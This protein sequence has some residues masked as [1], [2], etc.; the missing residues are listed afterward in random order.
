MDAADTSLSLLKLDLAIQ[1][2]DA[3]EELARAVPVKDFF[4]LVGDT[5]A[6]IRV[7]LLLVIPS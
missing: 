6:M 5:I 2:L 3:A 1:S 4:F 7:T